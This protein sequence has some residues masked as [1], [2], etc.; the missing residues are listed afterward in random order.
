MQLSADVDS[1]ALLLE[2][3]LSL[4]PGC[5]D[6]VH[7]LWSRHPLA[8]CKQTDRVLVASTKLISHLQQS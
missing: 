7:Q 6:D 3:Q 1:G 4:L 5:V 2:V 8:S